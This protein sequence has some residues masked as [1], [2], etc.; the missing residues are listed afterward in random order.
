MHIFKLDENIHGK[1]DVQDM[2]ILLANYMYRDGNFANNIRGDESD[3]YVGVDITEGHLRAKYRSKMSHVIMTPA[4]LVFVS[5]FDSKTLFRQAF[6][7]SGDSIEGVG[8]EN[9]KLHAF[10]RTYMDNYHIFS[11]PRISLVSFIDMSPARG[12]ELMLKYAKS[13][14]FKNNTSVAEKNML[15]VIA[16]QLVPD[17]EIILGGLVQINKDVPYIN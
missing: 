10:F 4:H 16:P 6:G 14:I 17:D 8:I 11:D 7:T 5:A 9:S 12:K 2:V 13:S 15:Y 3:L 1:I